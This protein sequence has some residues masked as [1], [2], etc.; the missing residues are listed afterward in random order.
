[1]K[2]SIIIAIGSFVLVSSG[3]SQNIPQTKVPSLVINAFQQRYPQAT[4]MEWEKD[5]SLYSV[6]FE[7]LKVDHELCIDEKGNIV[8]HK[9]EISQNELPFAIKKTLEIRYSNAQIDD[10]DKIDDGS[11]V[12]YIIEFEK[13]SGDKHIQ[14]NADGTL[15]K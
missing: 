10:I 14:M 15:V 9:Q 8:K 13:W 4:D 2:V 12:Y 11:N 5:G 6:E 7:V 1:M 3:C